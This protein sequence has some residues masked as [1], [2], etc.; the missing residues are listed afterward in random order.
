MLVTASITTQ[1]SLRVVTVAEVKAQARIDTGYEDEVINGIIAAAEETVESLCRRS[2]RPQNWLAYYTNVK[3]GQAEKLVRAPVSSAVISY[4]D[5]ATTW[6]VATPTTLIEGDECLWYPPSTVVPY[7]TTDGSPNWKAAT[8]CGGALATIP[9]AV[10]QA[11][12]ILSAH[13]YEQ[14]TPIIIGTIVADVP[15]S[16]ESLLTPHTLQAI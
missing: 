2:F 16:V 10:K 15:F 11:I 4:R 8:V 14:R 13:L 6:A 7:Q 5:S 1:P 9:A 3:L 12:L